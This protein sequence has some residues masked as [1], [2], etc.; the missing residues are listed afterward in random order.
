MFRDAS[1]LE[2]YIYVQFREDELPLERPE[3]SM[4]WSRS[5]AKNQSD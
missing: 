2:L 4:K 1:V 5:P 3:L